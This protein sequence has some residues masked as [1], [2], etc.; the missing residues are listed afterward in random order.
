MSFKVYF[1][2]TQKAF[3][4]HTFVILTQVFISPIIYYKEYA[5]Q[6]SNKFR[7][8]VQY[9][10]HTKDVDNIEVDN[11]EKDDEKTLKKELR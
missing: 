5:K 4:I 9:T 2:L 10:K 3:K 6:S 11:I 1:I 7:V 8:W